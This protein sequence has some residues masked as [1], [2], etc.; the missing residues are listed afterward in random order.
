MTRAKWHTS[1]CNIKINE[2]LLI[3]DSNV[4]R[5]IWKLGRV[6]H[7]YP[8]NDG[9]VR[10]VEIKYKSNPKNKG[11]ETIRRPVQWLVLIQPA[12]SPMTIKFKGG[13]FHNTNHIIVI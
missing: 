13:V 1:K 4:L 7:V 11:L 12:M 6:S 8:S 5:G 2:I 3:Q 10:N 9:V